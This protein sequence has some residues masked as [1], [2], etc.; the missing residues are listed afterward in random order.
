LGNPFDGEALKIINNPVVKFWRKKF[1][2][3]QTICIWISCSINS[4]LTQGW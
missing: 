2:E 3:L 4:L 1:Q